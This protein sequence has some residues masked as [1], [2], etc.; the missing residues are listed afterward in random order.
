[1]KNIAVATAYSIYESPAGFGVV[2]ASEA[3]LVAHHLPFGVS[4]CAEARE[5]AATIAPEAKGESELTRAAAGLLAGYFAGGKVVFDLPLDLDGFT[6][7]QKEVYRVVAGIGYGSVL[8]Y[9][10]VAALC[11]SPKGARAVGGAMA[12]NRLPILIPCHRVLGATGSL[13]G[14]TAPGGVD[15]KRQLLLMEG[16]GAGCW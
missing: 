8:S 13:T 3:G 5:V 4:S 15:S 16:G 7:F 6:P 12:K 2:T 9:A 10:G 1:M 11:G 14:F